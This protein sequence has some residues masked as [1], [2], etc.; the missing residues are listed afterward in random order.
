MIMSDDKDLPAG[1]HGLGD[2][3][4][5]LAIAACRPTSHCSDA[6]NLLNMQLRISLL[7]CSLYM[8]LGT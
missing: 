6:V 8:T 1:Q 5:V 4:C 7:A 2:L 3:C